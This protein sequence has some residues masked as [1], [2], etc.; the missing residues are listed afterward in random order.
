MYSNRQNKT[1]RHHVC[2]ISKHWENFA[3]GS[4]ITQ[5]RY[6]DCLLCSVCNQVKNAN[7]IG[8]QSKTCTTCRTPW[9][10]KLCSESFLVGNNTGLLDVYKRTRQPNHS[11]ADILSKNNKKVNWRIIDETVM[12]SCHLPD[13]FVS[14][15]DDASS[16]PVVVSERLSRKV[17]AFAD[18]NLLMSADFQQLAC[19]LSLS[20]TS[21]ALDPG[22]APACF[23]LPSLQLSPVPPGLTIPAH[24]SKAG[25]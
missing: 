3:E 21:L 22:Q 20:C 6:N 19:S 14:T 1:A 23:E 15:T 16:C 9:I 11:N 25:E 7:E 13:L 2:N 17:R 10:C 12:V 8:G 24:D 5:L 4:L 18:Y